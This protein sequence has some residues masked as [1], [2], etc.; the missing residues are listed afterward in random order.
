MSALEKLRVPLAVYQFLEK[1]VVT[2]ALSDGFCELF[3][4]DDKAGAYYMMDNDMYEATHPDD[5]SRIANE[6]FR[7]ATQGGK[8]EVIYRT[9]TDNRTGYKI[10]HAVGEHVYTEDGVRLAYVWYTDEGAYL[11]EENAHHTSLNSSLRNALHEESIINA[12][13]YDFL[14]GLPSMSYFF[15]LAEEGRKTLLENGGAYAILYMDLCGMKFY[16]RTHGFAEGDKLLRSFANLLKKY[17]S[18]ENCSRFGADHFC[19]FT[20]DSGLEATLNKIFREF[21]DMKGIRIL[22]V[23]AGICVSTNDERD[24]STECDRAKYACDTMRNNY[25]SNYRYFS[26][27]MLA[28]AEATQYIIDHIDRAIEEKWIQVYYQPII[29]AANGKVCDEEALA[30]WVDPTR[31][32]LSPRD[33]IPVLEESKLIYKLD[34]YIA[35]QII[36]NIREQEEQGL[37]VTS[38]SINLSRAD[39]EA[40]DIVEE[41]RRRVDDAG[42]SR[43]KLN[44]EIT[45]SSVAEN[46]D[47]MKAQIE[48]FQSLGFNVWMDDFGS[49]Y[50]S[51]DM[52]HIISFDLIKFDM[53]FMR[54][55]DN[56]DK[57][58][59]ILTELIKMCIAL[60]IDTVCEGVE[61]KE[62]SDFLR[63]IGCTKL[64]GYYFARPMSIAEILSRCKNGSQI[65][66]ENPLEKDY[67]SDIGKINLYDLSVVSN[68]S[69]D[70]LAHYFNTL[71]MA[72]IEA[73]EESFALL[74]CNNTFR[75]FMEKMFDCVPT[76]ELVRYDKEGVTFG[77]VFVSAL[78]ECASTGNKAVIDEQTA[79]DSIVHAI[80]KRISVNP[81]NNEKAIA[82]A[83]LAV[84]HN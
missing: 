75:T 74:R 4:Y 59:V 17:F 47:F 32:M 63:E 39:F 76:G 23:R 36:E 7:F 50:S 60:G 58:R 29:R 31:G 82:L 80:L 77:S 25:I 46:I 55:F 11:A 78:R 56:S 1:R 3:E 45:E 37:Y 21:R 70:D 49:G 69:K 20:S 19:V 79:D 10:V 34:L 16:N 51:L 33:F 66:F 44:I 54:E 81:V 28:K 42:V 68:D 43:D 8:Y 57:S 72:I 13:H 5:I 61:T 9:L 30:R 40:C 27:A 52:L 71:P 18:N 83:I 2:I 48:R 15:E 38:K 84:I 67:Y 14:T 53:H 6:A 41:I 65:G 35:E 64:Q 12:N 24:I 26:S 73:R 62:Q 22:P